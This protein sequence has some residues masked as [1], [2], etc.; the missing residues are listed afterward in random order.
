MKQGSEQSRLKRHLSWAVPLVAAPIIYWAAMAGAD[1][2]ID[3]QFSNGWLVLPLVLLWLVAMGGPVVALVFSLIGARRVFR[4]WRR[5]HGH[6]TKNEAVEAGR[7]AMSAMAWRQAQD[8]QRQIV[9]RQVPETIRIWDVVPNANEVFFM[10]VTADYARHY[11]MHVPYTQTSAFYFGRPSFVLA[12]LGATAISNAARRN[13]AANQAAPQWRE[14]QPCRL[15]VSNQRLLCQVSGQWL[16][17]YYSGMTASYPEV[18][19]WT[20][21]AQFESTSPLMLSGVN[22]PSAALFTVLATHGVEAV[23]SHPSLQRLRADSIAGSP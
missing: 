21:I 1:L 7:Q 14:H 5:A 15:V 8:L 23:R 16:G 20:L 2:L 6:Y 9:Q 13:A 4:R 22:V 17:F 11:G 10:D 3:G 18:G 12:G 19:N